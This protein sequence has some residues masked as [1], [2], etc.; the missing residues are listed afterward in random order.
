[1][2]LA[3]NENFGTIQSN[4]S[5][6]LIRSG[7][8]ARRAVGWEGAHEAYRGIQQYIFRPDMPDLGDKIGLQLVDPILPI[9]AEADKIIVEE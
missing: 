1:M 2:V 4:A 7:D 6:D 5:V 3:V 9:N 8:N